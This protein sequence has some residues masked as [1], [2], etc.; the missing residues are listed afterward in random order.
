[1]KELSR[2]NGNGNVKGMVAEIKGNN[3]II[4][5][6]IGVPAASM[7]G[8]TMVVASTHGNQE[9]NAEYKGHRLTVGLNAY[10]RP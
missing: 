2:R 1:M 10:Y 3:L 9:T 6:P 5:I 8:K 4:T 7:S